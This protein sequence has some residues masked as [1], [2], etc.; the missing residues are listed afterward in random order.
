MGQPSKDVTKVPG[1]WLAAR[2][3][4]GAL[5]QV[6]RDTLH[7]AVCFG[8]FLLDYALLA[9]LLDAQEHGMA[10]RRRQRRGPV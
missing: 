1:K 6:A 9:M 8:P 5:S 2:A 7:G 3:I 10:P 4:E